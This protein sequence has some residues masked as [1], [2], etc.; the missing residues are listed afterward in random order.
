[1]CQKSYDL[2]IAIKTVNCEIKTIPDINCV[3]KNWSETNG[4][5]AKLDLK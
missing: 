2:Q 5:T 3:E 1:M 4:N